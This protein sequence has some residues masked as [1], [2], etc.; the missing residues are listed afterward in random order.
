MY[1]LLLSSHELTG[2]AQLLHVLA[3]LNIGLKVLGNTSVQTESFLLVDVALGVSLVDTLVV[4]LLNKR[5]E[6]TSDHVQLGLGRL[7]LLLRGN[8]RG[9]T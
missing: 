7:N 1:K 2:L 3:N 4:A 5:V 6:H 8:L 9:T